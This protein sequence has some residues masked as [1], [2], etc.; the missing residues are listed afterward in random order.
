VQ[1]L[2]EVNPSATTTVSYPAAT[3]A[4]AGP[5]MSQVLA[6][7][8]PATPTSAVLGTGFASAVLA[9]TGLQAEQALAI[10]GLLL[11]TGVLLVVLAARRRRHHRLA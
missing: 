11:G 9:A 10:G 3:A 6:V 2:F 7:D 4:C 5:V 1:I 8:D